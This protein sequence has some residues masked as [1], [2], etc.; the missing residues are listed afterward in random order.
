MTNV[1]VYST[2]I[3]DYVRIYYFQLLRTCRTSKLRIFC[4]DKVQLG[5]HVS[6]CIFLMQKKWRAQSAHTVK[7]TGI[8]RHGIALD[9]F[10]LPSLALLVRGPP[11]DDFVWSLGKVHEVFGYLVSLSVVGRSRFV[12]SHSY[13]IIL[14]SHQYSI[15]WI[16]TFFPKFC[17]EIGLRVQPW[18]LIMSK[19]RNEKPNAVMLRCANFLYC[20][21]CR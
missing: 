11:H 4:G 10:S 2:N 13:Q 16:L 3:A 21:L 20:R 8:G 17:A 14:L 5:F 19:H 6:A 7:I 12:P 15:S 18:I 9:K 1:H